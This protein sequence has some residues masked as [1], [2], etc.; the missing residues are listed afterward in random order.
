MPDL[1]ICLFGG[2]RIHQGGQPPATKLTHIVQALLAYLLIN[3]RRTHPRDVIV[4][5]FWGDYDDSRARN[6]LNTALWRLRA[7]LEPPG[8]PK[9]TYLIANRAEEIGFNCD[10]DYWLDVAA[11]EDQVTPLLNIPIQAAESTHIERMERALLLYSGDLLQG[12]YHDWAIG[13]RER[14]R[15]LYLGGYTYLMQFYKAQSRYAE[16]LNCGRQILRCEPLLEHIHRDMMLL[17]ANSGQ[18]TLA[19]RQYEFC[20]QILAK[21]MGISPMPETQTLFRDITGSLQP[22][23]EGDTQKMEDYRG[24][25]NQLQQMSTMFDQ[26]QEQFQAV[27][28]LFEQ[29]KGPNG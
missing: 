3:R 18:R 7:V 20:R 26:L 29:S 12:F 11:F 27:M 8:V 23:S 17:Y 28:H 19:V 2:L 6:C 14:L 13:E 4:E 10:S 1:E 24:V 16:G 15:D 22:G 5:V 9:G 25:V 21:E